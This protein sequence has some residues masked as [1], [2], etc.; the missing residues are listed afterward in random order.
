MS[1]AQVDAKVPA[2]NVRLSPRVLSCAP[3]DL[4]AIPAR[5]LTVLKSPYVA[6]ETF[7]S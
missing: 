5:L 7:E 2:T 6:S 3:M 4:V 1:M